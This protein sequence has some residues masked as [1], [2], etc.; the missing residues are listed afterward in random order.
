MSP[1]RRRFLAWAGLAATAGA[2]WSWAR[3]DAL[4]P[5]LTAASLGGDSPGPLRASTAATLEAA[6][7]ALLD[8]RIE[9][10]HYVECFRWR[11]THLRGARALYERFEAR[12]DRAARGAG[13]LGFR[14]APPA[15]RRRVIQALM[16]VRGWRRV[17]RMALARDDERIARHVVREIFRRFAH[18][19]AWVLAGYDAWPG[20]PRAI[21]RIAPRTPA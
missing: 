8:E 19:D 1:T 4:R 20:M 11:A 14:S 18:T 3:R 6:A 2:V 10:T 9:P 15:E 17:A 12:V 21:A 5:W 13:F 16:P 7:L